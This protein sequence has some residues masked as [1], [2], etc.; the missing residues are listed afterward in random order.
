MTWVNL[1]FRLLD[2]N[3][4]MTGDDTQT[5]LSK[6]FSRLEGLCFLLFDIQLQASTT[7]NT[8]G[9]L[10]R[11]VM[12]RVNGNACHMWLESNAK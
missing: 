7:T 8:L 11:H 5:R 2:S 4:M 9:I 10:A 1:E 6:S 3:D 12:K